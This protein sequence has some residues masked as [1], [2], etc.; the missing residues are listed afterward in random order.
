MRDDTLVT[1]Q[2][3]TPGTAAGRQAWPGGVFRGTPG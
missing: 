1:G 2:V 3:T